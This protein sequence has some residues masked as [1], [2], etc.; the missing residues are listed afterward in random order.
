MKNCGKTLKEGVT[1]SPHL[2]QINF[3]E[4]STRN[5]Y[6]SIKNCGTVKF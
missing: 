3:S 5:T 2:Q 6:Y 4:S 1:K